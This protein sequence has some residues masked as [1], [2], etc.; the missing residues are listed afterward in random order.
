MASTLKLKDHSLQV[1]YP[2][3]FNTLSNTFIKFITHKVC[4]FFLI[5]GKKNTIMP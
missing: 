3:N 2:F 4:I 1:D 5:D